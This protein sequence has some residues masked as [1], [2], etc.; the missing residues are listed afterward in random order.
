MPGTTEYERALAE[1]RRYAA[2]F[3]RSALPGV[4]GRKLAVLACMD[5]R[6]TVEDIL[7]I[8]TGDAHI[9]RNA[10]GLATE[11]ALRSLIISQQLLGT[12]E[13]IVIGHTRCGML[14]FRDDELRRRLAEQ[15]GTDVD[16]SFHAFQDLESNIRTQIDLIKAHPWTKDVPVHGLIYEVETGRLRE[17]AAVVGNPAAAA[18]TAAMPELPEVETI[19]RD[20]KPL[21]QGATIIGVWTDWPRSIRHPDPGSFGREVVGR[22]DPGRGTARQVAGSVPLRRRRAGRPGQDDGPDLCGASRHHPRPPRPRAVRAGRRALDAVPRHP[23]VRARR[24]SIGGTRQEPFS[25]QATRASCLPST[26]PNRWRTTSRSSASE[27]DCASGGRGSSRCCWTR[28]SW[29]GSETS[30]RTRRFGE[31]DSI[32]CGPPLV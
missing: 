7:A 3:D 10:G 8:R 13:V 2:Q 9:I 25:A 26:V 21:V 6:M 28:A 14:T 4:P 18:D 19:A 29:P 24:A 15:T 23:Q 11:D 30:T 17:V 20:L 32:R 22:A 1:N 16:V 5:A 27:R 12:E 31:R